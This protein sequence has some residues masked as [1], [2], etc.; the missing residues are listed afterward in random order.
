[1]FL[2]NYGLVLSFE[3]LFF[4]LLCILFCALRIVKLQKDRIKIKHIDISLMYGL[5]IY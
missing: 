2:F 5:R 3:G 1:M 4:S